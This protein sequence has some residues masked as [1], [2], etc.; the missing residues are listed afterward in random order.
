M[1]KI[2]AR[3]EASR[4][5]PVS[6]KSFANPGMAAYFLLII[7]RLESAGLNQTI[8]EEEPRFPGYR[9]ENIVKVNHISR[10]FIFSSVMPSV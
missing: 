10:Q 3:E 6:A 5:P 1:I 2:T 8:E 4:T 9:G 7:H